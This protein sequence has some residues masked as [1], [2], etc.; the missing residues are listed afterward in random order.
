[1]ITKLCYKTLKYRDALDRL[2]DTISYFF[3]T[4]KQVWWTE[5]LQYL[6][7]MIHGSKIETKFLLLFYFSYPGNRNK[8]PEKEYWMKHGEEKE[9]GDST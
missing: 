6:K 5:W 9:M 8:L 2:H 4:M 3:H 1:M 7:G